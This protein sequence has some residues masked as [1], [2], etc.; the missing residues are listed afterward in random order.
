MAPGRR[1]TNVVAPLITGTGVAGDTI[2]C[3]MAGR[4]RLAAT[5]DPTGNWSIA[6][7]SLFEGSNT[8]TATQSDALGNASTASTELSIT[9]DTVAPVLAPVLASDTGSSA[10]DRIT[11]IANLTGTAD[12]NSIVT[13]SNGL[14]V[15][16]TTTA[17]AGGAWSFAPAGLT[18]GNYSLTAT[19]TDP[20][21]NTGSAALSF[22]LDTTAL[23]APSAPDLAAISDHGASTTDNITNVTTPTFTGTAAANATVTLLEGGAFNTSTVI[24]SGQANAAGTWSIATSALAAG[25]HV[26]AAKTTDLAGNVSVASAPLSV[27]IDVTPPGAPGTPDLALASDSGAS[28]IDNITNVVKPIFTGVAD[29]NTTATLFDG[30]TAIGTG[31]ADS[32]GNW[33]VTASALADGDHAI[34][35]TSTDLAGNVSVASAALTVTIDTAAPVAPSAPDLAPGS[36]SGA[37]NSDNVTSVATP[38]FTGTAEANAT[39]TLFDG[40]TALAAGQADAAGLWSVTTSALADGVHA[41]TAQATDFAGNIGTPSVALSVTIDTTAP[42]VPERA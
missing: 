21:D 37:S 10:T 5:V 29:P 9:L 25:V 41:I 20:A 1:V 28:Q 24:G 42:V 22:T 16:G 23:A 11:Q 26:I 17:D 19:E 6:A 35:A 13:I 31:L 14:T 38:V 15:L 8:L 36:D 27:T 12:A 39:V 18:D 33:S 32:F 7:S 40:A 34:T 2:T 3:S 4:G 30:T